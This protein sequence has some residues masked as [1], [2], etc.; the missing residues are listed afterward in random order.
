MSKLKKPVLVLCDGYLQDVGV[1]IK[2]PELYSPGKGA[3][4]TQ[5]MGRLSP[6]L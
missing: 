1:L 3:V 6:L 2:K 5:G 4:Q